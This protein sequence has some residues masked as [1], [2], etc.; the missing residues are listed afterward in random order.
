MLRALLELQYPWGGLNEARQ[1]FVEARVRT[2]ADH[3]SQAM[4]NRG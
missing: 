2:I 1:L 4:G 3:L